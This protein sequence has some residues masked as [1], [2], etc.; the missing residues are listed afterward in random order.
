MEETRVSFVRYAIKAFVAGATAGVTAAITNLASN[1]SSNTAWDLTDWLTTLL[2]VLSVFG[3]TFAAP[4]NA[5]R[6]D[7][8]GV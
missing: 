7:N 2:A 3:V 8:D 4:K 5:E 1:A 6:N